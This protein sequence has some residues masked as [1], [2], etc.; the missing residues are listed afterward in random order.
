M[1]SVV[2][3][4]IKSS[5]LSS[6]TW[7]TTSTGKLSFALK[8]LWHL[9]LWLSDKGKWCNSDMPEKRI[10]LWKMNQVLFH[11]HC[12]KGTTALEEVNWP[13]N[14]SL[15]FLLGC[16][17]VSLLSDKNLLRYVSH[18]FSVSCSVRSF[19]TFYKEK[20]LIVNKSNT[21]L[22]DITGFSYHSHYQYSYVICLLFCPQLFEKSIP[23]RIFDRLLYITCSQNW[24]AM[25]S[26]FWIKQAA[27]VKQF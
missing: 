11:Y 12:V 24:E 19:R 14:W 3:L 15:L 16:A 13:Q 21:F 5:M 27:E 18:N 7:S 26:H 4:M 1:W 10:I 22:C 8:A 17:A 6:L 25:G 9:S 2:F 23:R 20:S